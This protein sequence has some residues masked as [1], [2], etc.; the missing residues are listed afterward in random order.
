MTGS[1][2][3]TLLNLFPPGIRQWAYYRFLCTRW[4][5]APGE[6][7]SVPLEFAP[8]VR[9]RLLPSDVAHRC[10]SAIG[11]Y[12]LTVSRLLVRLARAGGLMVDVGA[13][14]GYHSLLWAAANPANRVIAYEASPRNAP[15]LVHNVRA[16]R[17]SDRIEVRTGIACGRAAGEMQFDPGPAEQS[18]WGGLVTDIP[19]SGLVAVP[20]EAL[21]DSAPAEG[22]IDLLKIDTEGADTWVLEG[23]RRLVD[24]RRIRHI[25]Y[26][27]YPSRMYALGIGPNDA[28]SLLEA[29][30][31]RVRHLGGEEWHAW[32]P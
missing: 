24:R 9:M 31:Y 20:V 25:L 5:P 19:R 3:R 8:T 15:H 27:Q 22:F 23:A 6:F 11:F 2:P 12:E 17:L 4:H 21:D 30:G 14:Y 1:W 29:A 13:N 18:G 16:N 7:E 26:E 28:R 10:M 32:L